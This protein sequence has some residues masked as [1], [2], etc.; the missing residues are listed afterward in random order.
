MQTPRERGSTAPTQF[1]TSAPDGG[2]WSA[3]RPG[4]ALPPGKATRIHCIGGRVGPRADMDTVSKG[5]YFPSA[6]D[7]NPVVQF[8]VRTYTDW[9]TAARRLQNNY[10][11]KKH[12]T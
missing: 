8:V 4:R 11:M 5:N 6:A 10:E 7:R 2:E 3:S 12:N 1:L 9:A